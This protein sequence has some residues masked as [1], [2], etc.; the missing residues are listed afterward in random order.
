MYRYFILFVISLLSFCDKNEV[1]EEYYPSGNLMSRYTLKNGKIH[2]QYITLH[3]LGDTLSIYNY[4][5][6]VKN[7][8]CIDNF[9]GSDVKQISEYKNGK[10]NGKFELI[11]PSKSIWI[12]CSY[13][14][15]IMSGKCS[16]LNDE[17]NDMISCNFVSGQP[18]E[19]IWAEDYEMISN[20]ILKG[21]VLCKYSKGKC[22][23]KD[24]IK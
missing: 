20:I 14:N 12:V 19:G 8:K 6:G 7:G 11:S 10:L 17:G 16:V 9:Y 21:S 4:E 23:S 22:I 15:D 2:G 18:Y 24:T 1:K 13:V 5:N 3:N